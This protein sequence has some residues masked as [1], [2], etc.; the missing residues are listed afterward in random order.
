MKGKAA[1]F[2]PHW[3]RPDQIMHKL[4]NDVPLWVIGSVFALMGVLAYTGLNWS[5]SRAT[6]QQVA[7]YNHVI[8]LA[9][10]TANITITL[11]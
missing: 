10:Q 8:A 9:P 2:A 7:A 5:L 11:P 6:T 1:G 3:A 4:R